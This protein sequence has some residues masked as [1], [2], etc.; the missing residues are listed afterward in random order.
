MEYREPPLALRYHP[1]CVRLTLALPCTHSPAPALC[2]QE[3]VPW[4]ALGYVIG[5]INYGGRVTDDLDRRCLM[6]ILRQYMTP[7][8]LDDDYRITPGG[9]G[10][11]LRS[12]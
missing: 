5:Q 9:W 3:N 2:F 11:C 8:V 4:P 7:M 1:L 12:V 10:I 6:S